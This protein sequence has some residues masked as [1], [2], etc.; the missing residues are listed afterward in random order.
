MDSGLIILPKK[1]VRIVYNGE[2]RSS[3][4]GD[5][6]AQKRKL[7]R[8]YNYEVTSNEHNGIYHTHFA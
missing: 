8:T 6:E 2:W 7:Y 1:I 4:T 3:A 5:P